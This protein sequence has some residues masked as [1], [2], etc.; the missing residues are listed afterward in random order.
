MKKY[1]LD[2]NIA[3]F[4]MKGKYNL[5]E[6][7]GNITPGNLFISEITLA[8]LKYGVENSEHTEK[9]RKVLDLFLTGVKILP[10]FHALDLYA[11]E[12]VRLQKAGTRIDDF[13]LLIGTTAITHNLVMVS[14]NTSHFKII[15]GIKLED[16][17]H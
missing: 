10:I 6:R 1:L 8:E 13:D 9:N 2:T 4:Y 17:A 15:K 11:K 3:I 12:K 7:F 16:W 14:N 5:D